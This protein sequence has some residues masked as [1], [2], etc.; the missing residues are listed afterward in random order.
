MVKV[1]EIKRARELISDIVHL[2]PTM[3]SRTL[4]NIAG[5]EIFLKCEHLQNTGSFKIRG[6]T[7]K[8]KNLVINDKVDSVVAASSGNHGQAVSYIA[9]ELGIS[10][11]IVVPPQIP[12]VKENAIRGYG[13]EVIYGGEN[14]SIRIDEAR[15]LAEEINGS[16]VPPFDDPLIIAGQG[17]LGLEILEQVKDVEV[18]YVPIGGGGLISGVATAIKEKNPSCKV[19]GVEPEIAKD[20]YLSIKENKIVSLKEEPKTIADGL[21]VLQPGY[22]TFPILNKYLDDVILVTEDEIKRTFT[23][24]LERAKQLVEPS[25]AVALAGAFKD[26]KNENK[27]SVVVISGGNIELGKI[28]E[29]LLNKKI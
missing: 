19:I 20:A 8:I 14:E 23:I 4:S 13:A 29:Y 28:S 2:T 6:A 3:R 22:L 7:N 15:E 21:R 10:A 27:T 24:I 26:Q 16:F 11:K 5:K 25:G 18:V 17:T 1:G 9:K 12:D